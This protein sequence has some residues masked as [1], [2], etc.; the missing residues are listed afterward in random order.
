MRSLL[1]SRSVP[2]AA[3]R[4]AAVE[5]AHEVVI[6]GERIALTLR[7]SARRSFALQV[8][9]RGAR[10]AVPHGTAWPAVERFVRMHGTWLRTRLAALATRPAAPVLAIADGAVLP[11]FGRGAR[12]RLGAV[13]RGAAWRLGADGAE[14]LWLS[15][16]A[17]AAAVV[18]ALR[19]R[20][21]AWYR[22]RVE[23]YCHRLGLPAPAVGLSSARTR[24]GSCSRAS[25]I[26]L[27]WRLI[28]LEPALI[29][30]VVAH[31]VAHLVEM[32]HSPRFWAVVEGLYPDWRAA[33]QRLRAAAASLPDIAAE[34]AGNLQQED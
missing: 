5:A 3:A 22:G 7:Q 28:H 25:G 10:V 11:L 23:E 29:D 21:L 2:P 17:D 31:E 8:D 16:R 6:D 1:R 18:R 32:N 34:R 13:A 26:R 20:G 30:Y 9:H 15:A 24:W 33:R 19:A 14:E 12:L 4:P 27:H